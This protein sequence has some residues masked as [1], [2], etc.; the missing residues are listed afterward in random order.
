MNKKGGIIKKKNGEI[1]SRER[2]GNE[3]RERQTEFD[4]NYR[5]KIFYST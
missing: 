3:E 5:H 1:E 4:F 2:T